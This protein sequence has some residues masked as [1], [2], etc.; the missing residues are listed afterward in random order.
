MPFNRLSRKIYKKCV[1][2]GNMF[3]NKRHCV[4]AKYCS[5]ECMVKSM[6]GRQR[7]KKLL[8]KELGK[9]SLCG[10]LRENNKYLLCLDCRMYYRRRRN[11]I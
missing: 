3:L 11:G 2:C 9:C 4:N 1:V 7:V 10:A 8:N 6:N 5:K